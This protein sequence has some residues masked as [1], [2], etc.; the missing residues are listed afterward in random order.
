MEKRPDAEGILFALFMIGLF[1]G[2][3]ITLIGLAVL[4]DNGNIWFLAL[5]ISILCSTITIVIINRFH[6]VL[7]D[8]RDAAWEQKTNNGKN[9]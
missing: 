9:C 4:S 6:N 8:I 2:I 5:G 3:V 1:G 7:L